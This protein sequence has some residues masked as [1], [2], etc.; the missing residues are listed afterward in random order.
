MTGSSSETAAPCRPPLTVTR[1]K[2][3]GAAGSNSLLR[4]TPGDTPSEA[5]EIVNSESL[6]PPVYLGWQEIA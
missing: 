4:P 3:N 2:A 5:S 6:M 1:T